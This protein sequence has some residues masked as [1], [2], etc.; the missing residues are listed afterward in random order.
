MSTSIS[1]LVTTKGGLMQKGWFNEKFILFRYGAMHESIISRLTKFRSLNFFFLIFV[2]L[3]PNVYI[4]SGQP[5]LVI[6]LSDLLLYILSL[7]AS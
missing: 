7:F 1:G 6:L 5:L 4:I 2:N 3:C